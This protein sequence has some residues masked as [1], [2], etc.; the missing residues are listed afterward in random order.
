M[1][2]MDEVVFRL[3]SLFARTAD[4]GFAAISALTCAH[5]GRSTV[6]RCAH[7]EARVP[8]VSVDRAVRK[9]R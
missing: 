4:A 8:A 6:V 9:V 7:V 2:T 3:L 1:E 5:W